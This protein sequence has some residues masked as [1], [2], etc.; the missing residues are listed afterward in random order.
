MGTASP[1]QISSLPDSKK[2]LKKDVDK[3]WGAPVGLLAHCMVPISLALQA[4]RG[5]P[6]RTRG[7]APPLLGDQFFM[8]FRGPKAHSNRPGGLSYP[9]GNSSSRSEEHT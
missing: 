1:Y 4:G 2:E 9:T 6:A 5:R 7:S 3:G 8:G